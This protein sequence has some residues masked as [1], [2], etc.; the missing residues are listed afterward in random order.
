MDPSGV[1][2]LFDPVSFKDN[3]MYTVG[4]G[5]RMKGKITLSTVNVILNTLLLSK[6][7][8]ILHKP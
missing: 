2:C 5:E 3:P 6:D 7:I 8:L 4:V 1:M